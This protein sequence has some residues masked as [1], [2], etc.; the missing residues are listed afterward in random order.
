VSIEIIAG[1]EPLADTLRAIEWITSI[2]A[3]PTV[4]V[5]RPTIGS[6]MEDQLPPTYQDMRV[7]MGA[8]YDACRRHW[9]PIGVA[10]NIEVSLVVNPDDAALLAPRTPGFYAYELWRRAAR[11]AL[12]PVFG[13]HLRPRTE[14]DS[15]VRTCSSAHTA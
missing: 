6:D 8:L 11:R 2:G 4:C 15:D 14:G 3:F 9:L 10:P 5:F 1:V 7:V 12:R 13:R